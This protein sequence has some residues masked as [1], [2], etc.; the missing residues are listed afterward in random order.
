MTEQTDKVLPELRARFE[1]LQAE[2]IKERSIAAEIEACDQEELK[3][4]REAV[5]EQG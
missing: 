3:S 5:A 2:L 1:M 4:Y